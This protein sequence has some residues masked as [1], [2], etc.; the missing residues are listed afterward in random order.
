M[1]TIIQI[2]IIGDFD[3]SRESQIKTNE[4]LTHASEK[5]SIKSEFKWIP[6]K[7]LSTATYESKI[8]SFDAIWAGPGDY[9]NPRGVIDVI[10]YCREKGMPFFGT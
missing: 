3:S 5:L 6:T 1:N 8:A 7:S 2:G 10:Q 4:S 9:D